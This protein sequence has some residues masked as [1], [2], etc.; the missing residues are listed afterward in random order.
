VV[1][2][3]TLATVGVLVPAPPGNAAAYGPS[4]D[5]GNGHLGAYSVGGVNV[6]CLDIEAARPT[7]V[8][9]SAGIVTAWAGV[10]A[11]DLARINWAISTYGQLADR[12]WT[13][14]VD[15]YVWSIADA[16][17]YNSH[18]MSGDAW[19][20]T[21]ASSGDRPAILANLTSLRVEG[22]V[23]AAATAP[24]A[25]SAVL[26]IQMQGTYDGIV[27]LVI[28]PAKAFGTITLSGGHYNG[29][30]GPPG[31][32]G[33]TTIVVAPGSGNGSRTVSFPIRGLPLDS[34]TDKYAIAASG[35]FQ[36][37]TGGGYYSRMH[38]Y[39]TGGAQPLAGPGG[40]P[41]ATVTFSAADFNTDPLATQFEPVIS[42]VVSDARVQPGEAI[43]DQLTVGLSA[44]SPANE[45]RLLLD[46]TPVSVVAQGRLYGPL[47]HPPA[48]SA[49]VPPDAPIAW[50]EILTLTGPGL[51]TSSS[52]FI[53]AKSGYYTWVWSIDHADQT[54]LT[55]LYIT[56][57]Y[58]WRDA[59]GRVA[60]TAVSAVTIDAKSQVTDESTGIWQPVGDMLAISHDPSTGPWW[61][62]DGLNPI[63]A[64]VVGR[65]YWLAG[66]VLPVVSAEPPPEAVLID[67]REI[68]SV[69]APGD[70]LAPPVIAPQH[71]NGYIVWQWELV[72]DG[73]NGF[74]AWKDE[75]GLASETVRV[76][77]PTLSTTATAMMPA[78]NSAVDTAVVGGEPT[79]S[80][81]WL[82][83]AIYGPVD[84][85]APVCDSTTLIDDGGDAMVEV[86]APGSYTSAPVVLSELGTYAWVATLSSAE[87][88]V[89]A[90]GTCGDP[91]ELTEVV[92]F[93]VATAA[94]ERT[95]V[96]GSAYDTATVTGPPPTG[97]TISFAAY[98]QRDSDGQPTCDPT[99]EVVVAEES[100]PLDGPG[101]YTSPTISLDEAGIYLWVETVRARDGTVLHEGECGAP[102][103]MTDVQAPTLALT[104]A[105]RIVLTCLLGVG[106]I[107]AGSVSLLIVGK[108][109]KLSLMRLAS[110]NAA[111]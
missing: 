16:A 79:G 58:V 25:N 51:Y 98:Y 41:P 36:Y 43:V 10:S 110:T 73:D 70:Y 24:A 100:L 67:T 102:H 64:H 66:D 105:P 85:D 50:T 76:T 28:T 106:A 94:V 95:T 101:V 80:S 44:T 12:R 61:T 39:L 6:Y 78:T 33:D 87:G 71:T 9:T 83:F 89:I 3:L 8:T 111:G 81:T 15:M 45:W 56:A 96:G 40:Q 55:P 52:G 29:P 38:V 107:L 11:A 42:T 37:S 59:F 22:A 47:A 104:G 31:N 18:G 30:A 2:A 84:I 60:E 4:Y 54:G 65:A 48:E 21:R 35:A 23:I 92:P 103:E 32:P 62:T 109:R 97:A 13:A 5:L 34:E 57:D 26:N 20:V 49:S 75:F 90:Q 99:N 91:T 1:V 46:G 108:R 63:S 74:V 68:V 17:S 27:N 82:R 69:S 19:F 14:A 86:L 93:V 72:N 77:I 53:A 88:E 7:G